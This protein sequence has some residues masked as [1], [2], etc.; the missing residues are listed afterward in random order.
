MQ[1]L[2][3]WLHLRIFSGRRVAGVSLDARGRDQIDQRI[4]DSARGG[5]LP[6]A[7]GIDHLPLIAGVAR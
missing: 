5:T 3:L 2:Q 4:V 6:N 7:S 1:K